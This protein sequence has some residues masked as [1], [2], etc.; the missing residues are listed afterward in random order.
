MRS[1]LLVLAFGVIESVK[2]QCQT[3]SSL[4]WQHEP[5]IRDSS[6]DA[7]VIANGLTY[8]RGVRWANDTLFVV[9]EG[10]GIV[11]Y[12]ENKDNCNGWTKNVLVQDGDLNHGILINGTQIYA[13]S[14]DKVF[15]YTWDIS[16]QTA[17][18]NETLVSGMDLFQSQ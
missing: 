16:S 2:G 7:F 1:T 4:S 10:V 14:V 9:D 13:S 15:R 12:V 5:S 17:S 18:G 6:L 8:P 3:T 11:T